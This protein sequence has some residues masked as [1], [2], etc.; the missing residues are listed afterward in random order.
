M[1]AASFEAS[2]GAGMSGPQDRKRWSIAFTAS[3]L[4]HNVQNKKAGFFLAEEIRP[5]SKTRQA[6][7]GL[8]RSLH[9]RKDSIAQE[10]EARRGT[11]KPQERLPR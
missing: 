10:P 8:I 11:G 4:L 5:D 2:A 9:I 7:M 3:A 6:S 1:T